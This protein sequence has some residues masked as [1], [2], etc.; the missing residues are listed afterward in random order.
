MI[1]VVDDHEDT[2]DVLARMLRFEG[3]EAVALSSPQEALTFLT[4]KKPSLIILDYNMPV[5]DGLTLFRQIR[6]DARLADV[7]VIMFSASG[8]D[9]KERSLKAGVNAFIVKA[10]LDWADLRREIQRLAGAGN[11]A[12]TPPIPPQP[13]SQQVV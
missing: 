11:P 7:P 12:R 9:L 8:G 5:I 3:Y 13:N 6:K 2:R 4:D 1:L 10:S